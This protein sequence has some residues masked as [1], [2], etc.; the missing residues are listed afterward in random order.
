MIDDKNRD[1]TFTYK[2]P[3]TVYRVPDRTAHAAQMLGLQPGL[4]FMLKGETFIDLIEDAFYLR[5]DFENNR[6]AWG[7]QYAAAFDA[8]RESFSANNFPSPIGATEGGYND[9]RQTSLANAFEK[10]RRARRGYNDQ[11]GLW[12]PVSDD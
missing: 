10:L 12:A 5:Q 4:G 7:A 11:D 2:V 3:D 9:P 1:P 6:D 8:D